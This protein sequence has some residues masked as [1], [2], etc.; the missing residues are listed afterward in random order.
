MHRQ[1]IARGRVAY[2]PNSLGV[3]CPFQAGTK[4]F[5]SF[6]NAITTDNEPVD[7]VRGKPEKF[8]EHFNQAS[9]FFNSQTAVEQA[10]IAAA[11]RFELSKVTIPAIRLRVLSALRNVSEELATRV[12]AGLGLELPEPMP[13]AL[14]T[15]ARPE[16]ETSAALSLAALPGD[17]GIATRKVAIMIADGMESPPIKALEAELSKAGAVTRFL[18]V[19]LGAVKSADGSTIEAD[20]TIE[21]SPSVL[22]DALVL[23]HGSASLANTA[24]AVEF[25]KDQ[26]RHCKTIL[27]IGNATELMDKA[28]VDSDPEDSGLI[29]T[30]AEKDASDAFIAA[31]GQHRH[32][33]R[34]RDPPL[35]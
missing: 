24:Q 16:V 33:E 6:P 31:L 1:A 5:V 34:D 21:N 4:G 30:D 10:H 7:K 14:E 20:A 12:A 28:G 23:P 18:G 35:V 27:A 13:K 17:G 11:F 2:E 22:F 19:R 9:L 8:A 3:G 15:P 25:F 32:F 29:V 26:F